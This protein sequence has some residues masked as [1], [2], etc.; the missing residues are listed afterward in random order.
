MPDTATD[1]P[2]DAETLSRLHDAIIA[3]LQ[4]GKRLLGLRRIEASIDALIDAMQVAIDTD[5]PQAL[6]DSLNV[7]LIAQR[8]ALEIPEGPAAG[9]CFQKLAAAWQAGTM[10]EDQR[11][12]FER[13]AVAAN[14]QFRLRV[15]H[16]SLV[17][18]H[19]PPDPAETGLLQAMAELGKPLQEARAHT[20]PGAITPDWLEK[21]E[22]EIARHNAL[23][24]TVASS[25][26]LRANLCYTIASATYALGRAYDQIS[27]AERAHGAYAEAA[28]MYREAH[29]PEDA[30]SASEKA[31]RLKFALTADVDGA[32]APDLERIAEGIES[33]L[34][35]AYTLHR[36]GRLAAQA[37]DQ[38]GALRYAASTAAALDKACFPDP[39]TA[40]M[41]KTMAAW[42]STAIPLRSGN[43]L[44]KLLQRIGEVFLDILGTRLADHIRSDPV[45]ARQTEA[46]IAQLNEALRVIM[47]ETTVAASDLHNGLLPYFPNLQ[48]GPEPSPDVG[49][50]RALALWPRINSLIAA[51][52]A[53]AS[54]SRDVLA[55]A[56]SVSAEAKATNQ[57]GLIGNA[58]LAQARLLAR[59]GDQAASA[60]AAEAGEEALLAGDA[61]PESIADPGLFGLFLML[62][63]HRANLTAQ[64]RDFAGVLD[65][66]EGAIAAI[67]AKRYRISDPFQQAGYLSER[68]LFYQMAAFSAFKLEKWDN[69][70]TIMDLFKS[71]SAL[72]NRLAPPLDESV[73]SLA[74]R[75]TEATRAIESAAKEPKEKQEALRAHRRLLWSL[76]SIV[77]MRRA[78]GQ[79]LPDI[80]L[81]ALQARL[82]PDEAVVSW[83][84]VGA[85]VLIVLALNRTG[86]HAERVILTDDEQ[87][88][89]NAYVEQARSGQMSVGVLDEAIQTITEAVLPAG[90]RRFIEGATR[91]IF[92]PHRALHL[93]PFHAARLGGKFLIEAASVRY[94]PNLGSL[95]I[96]WRGADTGQVIAVGIDDFHRD[97]IPSL[98]AAEEEARAV[99]AAWMARGVAATALTGEAATRD[100]FM[101]LDLASCR[102]LHLATHGSSVFADD[103]GGDPFA[104]R[105]CFLDGDVE[106]LTLADLPLR[107]SLVVMSACHSGQRALDLPGV[108][109]LPGDDLFGLQAALFQAGVNS[110]IGALWP[111]D[112]ES[113]LRIL[114]G[115]HE[116]L[117]EGLPPEL[118]LQAAVRAYLHAPDARRESFFWAPLFMSSIGRLPHSTKEKSR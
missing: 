33:P 66:A 63:Q 42:V 15:A 10:P 38:P 109:E 115:L 31:A 97:S 49:Y 47:S 91:L 74:E 82:A 24:D 43:A 77:R 118:A 14:I 90:A 53:E 86:V 111:L 102:C 11:R 88:W 106:A 25:N 50:E 8:R 52:N 67:E 64:A 93:L 30:A 40:S 60:G 21:L 51:Q 110:V 99:A 100:A 76:L 116:R 45:L 70:I 87:S 89:L 5:E 27:R 35:L 22:H 29:E 83:L 1:P 17:H 34:E 32:A 54:P 98:K 103:T 81:A 112:D 84:W 19:P 6:D 20:V 75:V 101:K 9:P 73:A 85:G 61:K 79:A 78:A 2:I 113:A 18:P 12:R 56:A 96:P 16:P 48:K 55:E 104:S 7:L 95:L 26:K 13:N 69:L 72:R 39:E 68:T 62:R 94:V 28:R 65:L 80:S 117:A 71:R 36:L 57:P 107:A 41:E 114:P 3:G 23:L 44:A 108:G 4:N 37:S 59:S 92:S 105:L 46:V 58:C